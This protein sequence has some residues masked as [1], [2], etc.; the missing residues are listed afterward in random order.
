MKPKKFFYSLCAGL[1]LS[2]VVILYGIYWANGQLGSRSETLTQMSSELADLDERIQN[3]KQLESE[4]EDLTET[5]QLVLEVLPD[6]KS[7]ENIV[8]E[9]ISIASGRGIELEN[10]T[11]GGNAGSTTPETSQTERVEGLA[12]VYSIEVKSSFTTT[13]ENLLTFLEDLETNKRRLEV[14]EIGIS[15]K[16]TPS[17]PAL[18]SASLTILTYLKP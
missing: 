7:Q 1:G 16:D 11:F 3:A 5:S 4:L 6:S 14:I 12:G 18:F 8:G 2:V 10:I 9:L 15:P 17:G 13:Y